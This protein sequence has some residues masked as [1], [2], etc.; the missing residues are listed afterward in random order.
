MFV[1]IIIVRIMPYYKRRLRRTFL[2]PNTSTS[3][4]TTLA[5][6]A[7]LAEGQFLHEEQNNNNNNN[8]VAVITI[9]LI[10]FNHLFIYMLTQ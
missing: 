3:L 5:A 10:K 9:R 8:T 7:P 2:A 6:D 1:Q 4:Q